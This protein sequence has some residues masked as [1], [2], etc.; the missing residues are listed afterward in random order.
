LV[1]LGSLKS[2]PQFRE[3]REH[4]AFALDLVPQLLTSRTGREEFF[5]L[6]R[7]A[8]NAGAELCDHGV[9]LR[10]IVLDLLLGG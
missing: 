1:G 3:I 6:G 4:L 7:L 10:K 9:V 2:R 8:R 5:A